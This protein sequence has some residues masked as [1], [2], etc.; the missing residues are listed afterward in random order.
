MRCV[1]NREI[2]TFAFHAP[3]PSPRT[4][5]KGV[6]EEKVI[7]PWSDHSTKTDQKYTSSACG[8][9]LGETLYIPLKTK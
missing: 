5:D 3:R 6:K 7:L 1:Y 9:G 4:G 8:H 2:L